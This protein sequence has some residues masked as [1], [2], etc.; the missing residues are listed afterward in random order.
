MGLG[1][2]G[3]KNT[4]FEA[5]VREVRRLGDLGRREVVE[6]GKGHEVRIL[7][8]VGP[9]SYC[10]WWG[11]HTL[12]DSFDFFP[13]PSV[14]HFLGLQVHL[15]AGRGHEIEK[16]GYKTVRDEPSSNH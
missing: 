13:K 14:T 5:V 8:F 10:C 4:L 9:K 16:R 11:C 15:G 7:A 6:S 1:L 2:G 3:G 12:S